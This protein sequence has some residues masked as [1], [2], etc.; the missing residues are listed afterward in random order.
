[1]QASGARPYN[2]SH[3]QTKAG[4]FLVI[5]YSKVWPEDV[6]SLFPGSR[7]D[8]QMPLHGYASTSSPELGAGFYHS[9]W[10]ILP[11]GFGPVPA[12]KFAIVRL[13]P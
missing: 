1:M 5:P 4:D 10:S 6:T 11:Y 2:W 12:D 13:A 7:E 3:P 9:Y 8:I